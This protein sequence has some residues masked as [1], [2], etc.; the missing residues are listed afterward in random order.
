LRKT[1]YVLQVIGTVWTVLTLL[2]LFFQ[3]TPL[4]MFWDPL[5]TGHCIDKRAFYAS[6]VII[7]MLLYTALFVLPAPVLWKLRLSKTRRCGLIV[8]FLLG[9]L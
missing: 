6:L 2:I 3:C 4:S 8:L 7:T 9:A 1:S 5:A